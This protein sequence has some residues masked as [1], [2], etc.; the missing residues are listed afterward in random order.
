MMN[1]SFTNYYFSHFKRIIRNILLTAILSS[2]IFC[3]GI[4]QLYSQYI[5][6]N[7]LSNNPLLMSIR[8]YPKPLAL[9][10][11]IADGT[12]IAKKQ[13]RDTVSLSIKAEA[14]SAGNENRVISLR[15]ESGTHILKLELKEKNSITIS[16]YN[17]L[18]KKVLD[19]WN[20]QPKSDNT[21]DLSSWKLANGAYICVVIGNDFRLTE[22]FVVLR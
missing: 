15:E 18:G 5:S 11:D 16:V 10:G 14:D 21:Y 3:A 8:H 7:P 20:N 13:R 19:V 1:K 17:L 22:K 9:K 4:P 6:G 12:I 2:F